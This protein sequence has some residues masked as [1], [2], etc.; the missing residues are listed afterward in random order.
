MK[1]LASLFV[2]FGL[3]TTAASAQTVS[4][5][6]APFAETLPGTN[7]QFVMVLLRLQEAGLTQSTEER[8]ANARNAFADTV[9]RTFSYDN[10]KLA[11]F[12]ES[13]RGEWQLRSVVCSRRLQ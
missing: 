5:L 4:A 2:A 6:P 1:S 9:C 11:T 13:P 7:P 10:A 8:T 12:V 3:A